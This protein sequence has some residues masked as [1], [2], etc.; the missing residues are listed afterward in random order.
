MDFGD[1][2][3]TLREE[4]DLSRDDLANR[5][6]ISYSTVSKYETN[7]RFPDKETLNRLADFFSVSI[8]YLLGRS[9]NRNPD[10]KSI[11]ETKAYY[12]LDTSGLP[13]EAIKQVEEYI[14]FVKL[15]YNPDGSLK[16][17]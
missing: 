13:E 16:N 2:L 5:L 12:N 3:K 6:N 10:D 15:K 14:E 11:N 9:N 1:R 17:K 4:D 7:V 8:D